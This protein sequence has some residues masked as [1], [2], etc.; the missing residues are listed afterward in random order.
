[1]T[2]FF[3][4]TKPAIARSYHVAGEDRDL[5]SRLK[6]G[7]VRAFEQVYE[8]YRPRVFSFLVRLSGNRE[9]A[10]DLMQD[11]FVKLAR[12]APRLADDTTLTAWLLTVA[13]NAYRS[14]RRWAML[15]LSRL[16]VVG[17]EAELSR[18]RTPAEETEGARL[19]LRM[20]QALASLSDAQREVLL[21][22]AFEDVDQAAVATM[23][24]LTD[25]ALRKRLSRARQEFAEALAKLERTPQSSS[26]KPA[27]GVP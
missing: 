1:V 23:L 21:L 15:D 22:V 16:L 17:A 12:S 9:L 2:I 7:N 10:E 13:R 26:K 11:T 14:H 5:V 19:A 25:A 6:A 4:V 3:L 8:T 20:E 24:G 18:P 27:R